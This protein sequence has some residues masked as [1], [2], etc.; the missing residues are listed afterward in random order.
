MFLPH[1]RALSW[2][3]RYHLI[4][5]FEKTAVPTVTNSRI[6]LKHI[7]YVDFLGF[8]QNLDGFLLSSSS[9]ELM[10]KVST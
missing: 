10:K 6:S 5:R 3:L 1:E 9:N 4:N 7:T 2:C 8:P